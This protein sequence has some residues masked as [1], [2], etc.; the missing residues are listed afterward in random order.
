MKRNIILAIMC[1]VCTMTA[2]AQGVGGVPT[3]GFAVFK[4]DGQ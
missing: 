1:T 3:N 4:N 2:S